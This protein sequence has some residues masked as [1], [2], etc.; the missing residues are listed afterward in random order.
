[1][2]WAIIRLIGGVL[3]IAALLAAC[4]TTPQKS[5]AP[6]LSGAKIGKPY[7]I[8]GRWYYPKAEPDYD[9]TGV[10]SWYGP[11]FHG[12]STANGENYDQN[13][14]TAAHTTLPLPTYVRVTNLEN[15][16]SLILR[17]NDRGPFAK[18]RIIDV[19]RR[20]AQLLGFHGT[21]TTQVRVQVIAPDQNSPEIM[22]AKA[23]E[24]QIGPDVV[25]VP[26]DEIAVATIEAKPLDPPPATT[27]SQASIQQPTAA[28]EI[29]QPSQTPVPIKKGEHIFVQ[30]GAFAAAENAQ[31]L[32]ALLQVISAV[33]TVPV[34]RADGQTLY[35][36][37]LGPLSSMDE[38]DAVLS[39]VVAR[40]HG[41]ARIVV[42]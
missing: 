10:A 7:Q 36:V 42:D 20:A 8:N 38:A 25:A 18:D 9:R 27:Y 39:Q 40:G 21:G 13:A 17:I 24:K 6:D 15:G 16:R 5:Q 28:I 4:A 26:R 22:Q 37:R 35:R 2:G 3:P 12:K 33:E 14:L 19:S 31:R 30:A 1:M 41:N 32:A 29:M 23:Q 34:N 11:G